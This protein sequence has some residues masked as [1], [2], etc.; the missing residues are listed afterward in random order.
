MLCTE[1]EKHQPLCSVLL[2]KL[3]V[4]HG[5]SYVELHEFLLPDPELTRL[6]SFEHPPRSDTVNSAY[7]F[8]SLQER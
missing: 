2:P 4:F 5:T 7:L 8:A 1:G 6:S 3:D